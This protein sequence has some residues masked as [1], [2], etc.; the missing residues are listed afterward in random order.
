MDP[1]TELLTKAAL[2]FYAKNPLQ[3]KDRRVMTTNAMRYGGDATNE[4]LDRDYI[5]RK[6]QEILPEFRNRFNQQA[7]DYSQG[8][9]QEMGPAY[10][11]MDTEGTR[12]E[13]LDA[14][15][16]A[17]LKLNSPE[18]SIF[19][20]HQHFPQ[21]DLGGIKKTGTWLGGAKR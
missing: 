3:D 4:R 6:S 11:M 12:E 18:N 8:A 16:Q 15:R 10:G 9:M 1:L 7:G 19:H 13:A 21:I 20:G 5:N 2:N 17:L 14:R